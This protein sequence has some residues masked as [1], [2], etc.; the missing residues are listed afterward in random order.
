MNAG[1]KFTG[2]LTSYLA[3]DIKPK[4]LSKFHLEYVCKVSLNIHLN[5]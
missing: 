4:I 3:V 5:F 2:L 1:N